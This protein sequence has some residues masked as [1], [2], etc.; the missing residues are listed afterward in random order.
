MNRS[1]FQ[2][3]FL[4]RLLGIATA[5][6]VVILGVR[7]LVGSGPEEKYRVNH[8]GG[9]SMIR[10]RDWQAS[11]IIER[12]SEGYRDAIMLAPD[13]WKGQEP[14]IW[15]KRYDSPPDFE[16]LPSIGF[17]QREFQGQPAWMNQQKP[18]QHLIRTVIFQRGEEWFNAG[19][20]LPGLEGASV[21]DW[22]RYIESVKVSGPSVSK[23]PSSTPVTNEAVK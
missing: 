21:E 22:W 5:V 1:F 11:I 20:A 14:Q 7:F 2:R 15:L 10:P 13:A 12:T 6:M 8:P 9:Y 17:L 4:V 18:K 16:K 3:S 23:I 19:V